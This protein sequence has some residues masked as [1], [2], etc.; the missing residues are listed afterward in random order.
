MLVCFCASCG[1]D[2]ERVT[3]GSLLDE[4]T[5][6]EQV[7][8][9]P[10]IPYV[11]RLESSHDRR[12]VT[13]GTP[14]WFANDDGFGYVRIDSVEGRRE[15]VLFEAEGPGA[16]TRIW[17]TTQNPAGLLRFY[18]DGCDRPGW[19][20][21]AYDLMQFGLKTLGRG[22]LQPH[23]SYEQ[24]VKG[25]STLYLPIP[26]ARGC[27]IT[28]EEPEWMHGVPHYYQVN[29]RVYPDGTDVETFSIAA[30]EKYRRR[31][32]RTERMLLDPQAS[33]P[34]GRRTEGEALLAPGDTLTLNLPCGE[35]MAVR[36]LF[37]VRCDSAAYGQAMRGL[38]FTAEF[39]GVQTVWAPLSDFSGGGMGAPAVESWFLSSDGAG[40]IESL[41]P[42]PY[43]E[44]AVLRVCNVSDHPCEVSLAVD[45]VRSRWDDRTLYF[46]A[47][48]KQER[49]LR[50][51]KRAEECYDWN[52]ATIDGRG[53]YR[54][55][56]LTLFNRTRAW[57]GEGDEVRGRRS[58][59]STLPSEG[60]RG[61][62]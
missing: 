31:L 55:D 49:G 52:F 10:G 29:Y 18:F 12:S 1:S 53:V 11:S 8:R 16:I 35:R 57:Y 30:V 32:M 34:G 25:G 59:R 17:L 45:V 5:S 6:R 21:P 22:L 26:Y 14:E 28:L 41:W 50:V 33:V 40:R 37:D 58:F 4:M 15:K 48:W 61:P 7:A 38:V 19:V 56:L 47:S 3:L 51:C 2:G 9:W 36:T 43:R 13:P 62:T 23:T 27:R 42:M 54:G 20:V 46:H 24:G 60:L 39:D 44:G